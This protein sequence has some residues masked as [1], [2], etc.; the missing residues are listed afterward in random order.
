MSVI[1][2]VF[3]T[4]F[5]RLAK[6]FQ[7]IRPMNHTMLSFWIKIWSLILVKID[8]MYRG[9]TLDPYLE[10][11][12]VKINVK[13]NDPWIIYKLH[14]VLDN[15]LYSWYIVW[16]LTT[17]MY[18]IYYR[19]YLP[20]F[21]INDCLEYGSEW[22]VRVFNNVKTTFPILKSHCLLIRSRYGLK[23]WFP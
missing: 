18:R 4:F 11:I 9:L 2:E 13:V 21:S 12:R 1:I 6:F 17:T 5:H 10:P 19:T 7:L 23:I 16:W 14:N 3:Y 15:T 20:S 8:C 22:R